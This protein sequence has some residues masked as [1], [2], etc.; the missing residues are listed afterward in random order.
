MW[1]PYG[2]AQAYSLDGLTL[3]LALRVGWQLL[4]L[5]VAQ[6]W[7]WVNGG[8]GVVEKINKI[9]KIRKNITTLRCEYHFL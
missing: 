1:L 9:N 8:Y 4:C 5:M 3:G 6:Y 2:I 7:Q